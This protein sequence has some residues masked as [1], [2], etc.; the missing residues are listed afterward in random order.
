MKTIIAN[1]KMNNSFEYAEYWLEKIL[2]H[3]Q[4]DKY[5]IILSPPAI[6][7]DHIDEILMNYELE[8]L[9]TV[10]DD[11]EETPEEEL[12][13]LMSEIRNIAISGQDCH[14]QEKG[15]FT[16][17]IS[18]KMLS[19]SGCEYVIIGHSERRQYHFENDEIILKKL[20]ASLKENLTPILC[21]GENLEVRENIAHI[22]F[23]K[24]QLE[25]NIPKNQEIENLIIA[26]EPIW[27][28]GTGK[29]P[30]D[31]EIAEIAKY[32]KNY[33]GDNFKNVKNYQILYGGSVKAAN[34]HIANIENIDGFLVGGA[35]VE[36]ESFIDILKNII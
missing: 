20:Q 2:N 12:E 17:D 8:K 21:I 36:A 11:I 25:N 34:A 9:E 16:G 35:S 18:A 1:W 15:A 31:N 6:M 28:I 4:N 3:S 10:I 24:N 27:S 32:I 5:K 13:K 22:E 29:V 14:Y 26:Y 30:T 19:E 33:I 7:I 23:V